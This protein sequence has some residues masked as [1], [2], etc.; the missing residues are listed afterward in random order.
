M[1]KLHLFSS[2]TPGPKSTRPWR[3]HSIV[4]LNNFSK[5]Q[6]SS[7]SFKEKNALAAFFEGKPQLIGL[8]WV[9]PGGDRYWVS[10]GG[11][12]VAGRR[13][14]CPNPLKSSDHVLVRH[15]RDK[16]SDISFE[17]CHRCCH[18]CCFCCC[19]CLCYIKSRSTI[20]NKNCHHDKS[21]MRLQLIGIEKAV[22]LSN[23]LKVNSLLRSKYQL[24]FTYC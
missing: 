21:K 10:R 11:W 15:Q 12:G 13:G 3:H 8:V 23:E 19:F 17:R 7:F 4:F 14:E 24:R 1:K 20:S 16:K 2:I 6:K 5:Q 22:T 18:C 9:L